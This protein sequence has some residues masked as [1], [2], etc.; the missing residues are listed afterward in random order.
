MDCYSCELWKPGDESGTCI[1]YI[2][3]DCLYECCDDKGCI[4]NDSAQNNFTDF[5]TA[6]KFL[7]NHKM[8]NNLFNCGLWTQAVKV[9]PKTNAIDSDP[10]KNTKVQI[11]LEHGPYDAEWGS[12]THDLDLDCG[13]DTFEEAIIELARLVQKYYT[14]E[15]KRKWDN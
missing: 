11:W 8:F 9:N 7:E 3:R 4:K 12:T 14:D 15:G 5:Y 2:N 1:H 13:G 6:W 10:T